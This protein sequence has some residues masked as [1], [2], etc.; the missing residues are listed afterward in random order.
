MRLPIPSPR[1]SATVLIVF[2][3]PAWGVSS[4]SAAHPKSLSSRRIENK[5]ISGFSRRLTSKAW[6]VSGA[7]M[8][9]I[10]S[11]CSITKSRKSVRYGPSGVIRYE[12]CSCTTIFGNS[13]IE[14]TLM[15]N[16]NCLCCHS[17]YSATREG[18]VYQARGQLSSYWGGLK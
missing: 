5:V 2:S 18:H 4:L 1:A 3:S 6:D 15:Q 9:S 8:S 17:K 10:S 16:P 7:D 14:T 13:V 11:K 12:T